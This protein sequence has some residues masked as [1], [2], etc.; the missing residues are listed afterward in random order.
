MKNK[1]LTEDQ[2]MDT[3]DFFIQNGYIMQNDD[4][5]KLEKLPDRLTNHERF[6]QWLQTR[7]KTVQSLSSICRSS[8]RRHLSICTCGKSIINRIKLLPL[9]NILID[10]VKFTEQFQNSLN[11][12]IIQPS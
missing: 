2:I 7:R 1:G 6:Q 9:P 11:K 12:L 10:Y 8:V 4:W 3:M 5:L